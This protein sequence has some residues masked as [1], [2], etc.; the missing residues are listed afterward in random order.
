MVDIPVHKRAKRETMKNLI[1]VGAG[2]F[3]REVL[4]YC[5]DYQHLKKEWEIIGFIDDNREALD[6]YDHNISIIDTIKDYSPQP[7][8]VFIMAIG[9][10]TE[11]K[12]KIGDMLTNKGAH[13]IS[14]LHPTARM[15]ESAS[16]GKG[17]VI[18]PMAGISCEVTLCNFITVNAYASVGHDSVLHDG[19]TI[20]PYASIAGKVKLGRGVSVSIHGCILPGLQVGEFASVGPGSVVVKNV[21]PK[22]TVFG[23]PAKKLF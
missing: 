16:I 18:A 7:N 13:F 11:N 1:I 2:G 10:P 5:Q 9:L 6:N 3:G 21:K 23:V 17:C 15:A 19:C 12:L 4:S 20:G 22:T 8:D 14:L